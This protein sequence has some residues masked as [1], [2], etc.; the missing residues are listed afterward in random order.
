MQ[1][2]TI[3]SLTLWL[4]LVPAVGMV[5]C[6]DDDTDEAR[7]A[8]LDDDAD[9]DSAG[10]GHHGA[11]VDKLCAAVSCS[12]EQ[13]TAL[14]ALLT[15]T[16]PTHP[17]E[18]VLT[19]A[20]AALAEAWRSGDFDADDLSGWRESV[21]D[22]GMGPRWSAETIVTAHGILD[23]KQ[24]DVLADLLE[25][26]GPGALFGGHGG[27]GKRGGKHGKGKRGDERDGDVKGK[28]DP[29]DFAA[30]MTEEL[31]ASISCTDEQRNVISGALAA[32]GPRRGDGDEGSHAAFAE[33]FRADTLATAT[34][35]TYLDA[36]KAHHDAQRVA[37]DRAMVTIHHV[38]TTE[39]RGTIATR[40]AKDGP[41]GLLPHGR[42]RKGRDVPA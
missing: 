41:R 16:A 4:A 21:H 6:D 1:V 39:Q 8:Q 30:H 38:L 13:R 37:R 34:V 17:S 36:M 24:R 5:G 33:A 26:R 29:E 14:T 7:S 10:P 27:K 25:T 9:A 11:P 40:I 18:E 32:S 35:Q 19:A 15:A 42:G 22:G 20:N 28:R 2:P 3:R 23:A 12:D 31:C